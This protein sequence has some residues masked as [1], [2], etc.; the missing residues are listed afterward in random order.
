M[1]AIVQHEYEA[2]Q[3]SCNRPT[4]S[5]RWVI[6]GQGHCPAFIEAG[7]LIE[8]GRTTL[9]IDGTYPLTVQQPQ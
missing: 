5:C 2:P 3:M 4:W 7:D 9:V 1:K 8:S 6:H